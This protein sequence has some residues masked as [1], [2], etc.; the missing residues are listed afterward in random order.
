MSDSTAMLTGDCEVDCQ[1]TCAYPGEFSEC[2]L[3]NR[4]EPPAEAE[5]SKYPATSRGDNIPV[6]LTA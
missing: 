4:E 1:D 2:E 3:G 6:S 5:G